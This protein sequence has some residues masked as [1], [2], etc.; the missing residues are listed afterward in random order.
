MRVSQ[1]TKLLTKKRKRIGPVIAPRRDF[2]MLNEI[3]VVYLHIVIGP[4]GGAEDAGHVP[5]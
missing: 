2:H 4:P 3:F 1:L 5:A